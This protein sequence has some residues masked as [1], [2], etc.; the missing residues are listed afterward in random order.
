MVSADG[1]TLMLSWLGNVTA[2]TLLPRAGF[3]I[4]RDFTH[5]TQLVAGCNV[6]LVVATSGHRRLADL[7][8]HAHQGP[9][10]L[11]Y[12]SAGNGGS[13][14]LAMELLQ[15]RSQASL[16]HV[17]YRDGP[18]AAG[19]AP[20][21]RLPIRQPRCGGRIRDRRGAGPAGSH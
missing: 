10:E 20:R 19:A 5:V 3:D 11:A 18:R 1:S 14:H 12:A 2:Q 6:L 4:E 13:T 15:Q 16:L 21:R 7:F 17:P 8:A 9:G